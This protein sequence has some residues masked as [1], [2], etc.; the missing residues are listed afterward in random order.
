M[1]RLVRLKMNS[2]GLVL[3]GCELEEWMRYTSNGPRM[4]WF[5]NRFKISIEVVCSYSV[6]SLGDY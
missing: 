5:R 1:F 4:T 2:F 6:T 3:I